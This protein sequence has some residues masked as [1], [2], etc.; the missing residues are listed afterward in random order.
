MDKNN[1]VITR[2]IAKSGKVLNWGGFHSFQ[3]HLGLILN[4]S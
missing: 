4:H 1:Q 3:L 2:N